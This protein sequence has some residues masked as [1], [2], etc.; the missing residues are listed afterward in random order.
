MHRQVVAFTLP[1]GRGSVDSTVAFTNVVG[2]AVTGWTVGDVVGQDT[3]FASITGIV[4]SPVLFTVTVH[5]LQITSISP[6]NIQLGG[7]ATITGSGFD[8][9]PANNNV[10]VGDLV[11]VINSAMPTQLDIAVPEACRPV[12]QVDVTLSSFKISEKLYSIFARS[13]YSAIKN[14]SMNLL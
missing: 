1:T 13:K 9:I 7:A 6:D 11:A 4:G 3:A 5:D 12:G 10:M 2:E 14:F 8:A